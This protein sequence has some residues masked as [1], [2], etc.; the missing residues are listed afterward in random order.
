L[1]KILIEFGGFL[2]ARN[3]EQKPWGLPE[4]LPKLGAS[5]RVGLGVA[6]GLKLG[7]IFYLEEV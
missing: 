7:A 6:F 3:F 2:L 1:P 4:A 5:S